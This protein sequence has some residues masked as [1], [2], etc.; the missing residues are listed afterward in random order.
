[1]SSDEVKGASQET[2][3]EVARN[4]YQLCLTNE[5][6]S[7]STPKVDYFKGGCA[8]ML[9]TIQGPYLEATF[10]AF[11]ILS[12]EQFSESLVNAAFLNLWGGAP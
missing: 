1:M 9:Q 2:L 4:G 10:R 5:G 11:R 7:V 8:S 6:G 3:W 12:S